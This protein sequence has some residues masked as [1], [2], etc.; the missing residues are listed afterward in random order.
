MPQESQNSDDRRHRAP[1]DPGGRRR[2]RRRRERARRPGRH[3]PAPTTTDGPADALEVLGDAF[4][5]LV[6]GPGGLALEGRLIPGL[7][8][9]RMRL[10]E[11][12]DLVG[13]RRR[14]STTTGDAVWSQVLLRVHVGD[15]AWRVAAAGLALPWLVEL[16]RGVATRYR[17]EP[18]EVAAEALAGF[19]SALDDADPAAR[20][21]ADGLR[22]AARRAAIGATTNVALPVGLAG[23]LA[24]LTSR[25]AADHGPRFA[26]AP[27]PVPYRHPDLVLIGAVADKVLTATDADLVGATRI[28]KR[29]IETWA[30][31]NRLSVWHARQMRRRAE[32]ALVAYLCDPDYHPL[33]VD[34]HRLAT[35]G[36]GRRG[37][38]ACAAA[39]AGTT[40]DQPARPSRCHHDGHTGGSLCA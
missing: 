13:R 27:P 3:D 5:A 37:W 18:A 31:D 26:S 33:L 23:D 39:A 40:G 2:R 29:S 35:A 4:D 7:P 22:S 28:D 19:L 36:A 20:N 11:I 24:A 25:H 6:D 15:A 16:T 9:R 12:R 10:D 8:D 38:C 30:A 32:Q 14:A 34:A 21:I 17:A 1:H